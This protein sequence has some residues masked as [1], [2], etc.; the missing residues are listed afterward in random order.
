MAEAE[1]LYKQIGLTLNRDKCK[2]SVNGSMVEFMGV[3]FYNEDNYADKPKIRIL[4]PDILKKC[5]EKIALY[6]KFAKSEIPKHIILSF[7][8]KILIP[9]ANYGAFID[10]EDSLGVYESID[11]EISKFIRELMMDIPTLD[12]LK[13][14]MIKPKKI[15]GLQ[16]LLP[17]AFYPTMNKVSTSSEPSLAYELYH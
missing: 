6:R 1:G 15:G 17:G 4:A 3:S 9:S 13:E 7:I 10:T 16:I 2:C 14:F 5:Q 12:E 8:N 11:N